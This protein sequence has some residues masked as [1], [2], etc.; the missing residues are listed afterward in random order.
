MEVIDFSKIPVPSE[1]QYLEPGMYRL[2]VDK[3]S[4]KVEMP[5]G[6]TPYLSV[7]FVE[8][9]GAA[10]TEKFFLTS[11]AMKRLQYLHEAWFGKA[12]TESFTSFKAVGEY[13]AKGLTAKIVARPMI[14]G[15]KQTADGKFYSGLPFLGF[16]VTDESVFDEGPF[17]KDSDIYKRVVQVQKPD[18]TVADTDVNILPGETSDEEEPWSV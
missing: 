17:K 4:V 15:G 3:E 9:G 13:F 2:K 8:K 18:P 12:L 16:V 7:R 5:Q 11:K 1:N 14:V 6:K 10:V